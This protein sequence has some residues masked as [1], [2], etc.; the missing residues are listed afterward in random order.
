MKRSDLF[1]D[2]EII[3]K[4]IFN[5]KEYECIP[6]SLDADQRDFDQVI[7]MQTRLT[8]RFWLADFETAPED[9]EKITYNGEVLRIIGIRKD[10]FQETIKYA[11]GDEYAR[12]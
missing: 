7:A 1:A 9:G 10:N 6:S 8:L 4:S 5:A 12:N 3:R 2:P 11:L